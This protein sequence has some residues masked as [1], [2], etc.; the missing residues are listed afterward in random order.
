MPKFISVHVTSCMTRQDVQK[1][2]RRFAL[3]GTGDVKSIKVQCDT[4]A[5]RMICEWEATNQDSLTDWLATRN[6][7]FRSGE[8][9]IAKIQIETV[10]G[11]VV[12]L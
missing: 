9:W 4:V 1:L 12:A 5:G 3:E 8:E 6:V 7:R 10:D 2:A 11:E